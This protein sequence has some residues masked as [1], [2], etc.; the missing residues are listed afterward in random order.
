MITWVIFLAIG[1]LIGV[2]AGLYFSRL[3]DAAKRTQDTLSKQLE[4]KDSELAE[5][6]EHVKSHFVTTADLINNMT[7]SYR[8]VHDHLSTGVSDLCKEGP[9]MLGVPFEESKMLGENPAEAGVE[10]KNEV[11]DPATDNEITAETA[12]NTDTSDSSPVQSYSVAEDT[13]QTTESIDDSNVPTLTEEAGDFNR[14]AEAKDASSIATEASDIDSDGDKASS[15]ELMATEELQ[16]EAN[17]NADIQTEV[18]GQDEHA[19]NADPAV[20]DM[21]K[22]RKDEN[23]VVH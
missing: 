17:A 7:E 1:I 13:Q 20:S 6:K 4:Q 3:D 15:D 9:S 18:E 11:S 10:S 19:L 23:R 2:A 22:S 16:T 5:Y 14:A 12:D 8:A 21:E